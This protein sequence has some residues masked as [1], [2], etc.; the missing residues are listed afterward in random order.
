M[1]TIFDHFCYLVGN[2]LLILTINIFFVSVFSFSS[3]SMK[4]LFYFFYHNDI[5][6]CS[7]N[8]V[9]RL[10]FFFSAVKSLF[11]F[12]SNIY[13]FSFFDTQIESKIAEKLVLSQ[14]PLFSKPKNN[15]KQFENNHFFQAVFF[16]F[17]F[18]NW[19]FKIN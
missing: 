15:S 19:K 6:T 2:H 11:V 18:S 13:F 7:T 5:D 9:T 4:F 14:F 17:S 3:F 1:R 8:I 12:W 10:L 16:L